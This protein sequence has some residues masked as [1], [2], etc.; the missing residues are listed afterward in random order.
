MTTDTKKFE[1]HAAGLN[2]HFEPVDKKKSDAEARSL[3][4][5]ILNTFK[6][7]ARIH[8]PTID[9][10]VEL[11]N[12]GK[13][14]PNAYKH[15]ALSGFFKA[16]YILYRVFGAFPSSTEKYNS[17]LEEAKKAPD[18]E[19]K[20][21]IL[22]AHCNLD[23][24][25]AAVD[26]VVSADGVKSIIT[27]LQLDSFITTDSA[28][29]FPD[30]TALMEAAAEQGEIPHSSDEET[31]S[32]EEQLDLIQEEKSPD[33]DAFKERFVMMVGFAD[34]KDAG[35]GKVQLQQSVFDSLRE[36]ASAFPPDL[37]KRFTD[38][39]DNHCEIDQ[40]L[41]KEEVITA[42]TLEEAHA[43]ALEFYGNDKKVIGVYNDIKKRFPDD[44]ENK[45]VA[46]YKANIS[47]LNLVS[48]KNR[49]AFEAKIKDLELQIP[50]IFGD[51]ENG[52]RLQQGI[53]KLF[54][55]LNTSNDKHEFATEEQVITAFE[56]A[57]ENNRMLR[58]A[59]RNKA[60]ADN[61]PNAF[62]VP[63]LEAQKAAAEGI[64]ARLNESFDPKQRRAF[65]LDVPLPQFM[66][67][68]DYNS[69]RD[70]QTRAKEA[71]EPTATNK[72]GKNPHLVGKLKTPQ[73]TIVK[74]I[75][76]DKKHAPKTWE[77]IEKRC[78][79]MNLPS[80]LPYVI[81][82]AHSRKY[83]WMLSGEQD[84]FKLQRPKTVDMLI[85]STNIDNKPFSDA[86][87]YL[88]V[89]AECS[90]FTAFTNAEEKDVSQ[91]EAQ[92]KG[93]LSKGGFAG[94]SWKGAA[95]IYSNGAM[96]QKDVLV[97]FREEIIALDALDVPASIP[98]NWNYG[99]EQRVRLSGGVQAAILESVNIA[100]THGLK[101]KDVLDGFWADFFKPAL[102][103]GAES[104]GVEVGKLVDWIEDPAHVN[105]RTEKLIEGWSGSFDSGIFEEAKHWVNI[106]C[107]KEVERRKQ[108]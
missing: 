42:S 69:N 91:L 10:M 37:A 108:A 3:F 44:A 53:N 66:V 19:K 57:I 104:Y 20:K 74:V 7:E 58:A 47:A 92:L 88:F 63:D 29:G 62:K 70:A 101:F 90:K 100:K 79:E 6:E 2:R 1:F 8:K 82:D 36:E 81:A 85:F 87:F 14:N 106:W 76:I 59:K 16:T 46:E 98:A 102:V 27:E 65:I 84:G 21:Q 33:L 13:I 40:E 73:Q 52:G 61:P 26:K 31:L 107:M 22:N 51:V 72:R 23:V 105:R 18:I 49:L 56:D 28:A 32:E 4:I 54:K 38:I 48:L 39:L 43:E 68:N 25:G 71:F 89:E 83:A 64:V 12:S 9:T 24:W 15:K 103:E 34:E 99:K 94:K 60:L 50:K 95:T 55:N 86:D 67:L 77:A 30:Y 41:P 75:K 11:L 45:G 17:M 97:K 93:V 5:E 78:E 35:I 80:T 96:S